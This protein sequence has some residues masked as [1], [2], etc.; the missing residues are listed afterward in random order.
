MR[1]CNL[2]LLAA[3]LHE[4]LDLDAKLEVFNHLDDCKICRDLIYQLARERDDGH[5]VHHPYDVDKVMHG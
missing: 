5:F 1:G 4:R 2:E 3:L